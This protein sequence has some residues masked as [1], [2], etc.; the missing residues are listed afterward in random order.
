MS[1][2]YIVAHEGL[3]LFLRGDVVSEEEFGT[4]AKARAAVVDRLVKLGAVQLT[5]A[6]PTH[7]GAFNS[8]LT[9]QESD[10][11]LPEFAKYAYPEV[12]PT[13]SHAG[14]Y[15]PPTLVD[16]VPFQTQDV[17]PPA[18]PD[19]SRPARVNNAFSAVEEMP[20]TAAAAANEAVSAKSTP[21]KNSK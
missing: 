11:N 3:G 21:A 8:R 20:D 1:K 15:N 13:T 6:E 2:Q 12:L 9:V 5:D 10:V 14:A 4:D 7:T 17:P 19:A 18:M 16:N